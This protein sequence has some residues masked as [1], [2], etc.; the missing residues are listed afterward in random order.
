MR[1]AVSIMQND[2]FEDKHMLLRSV[3]RL[4]VALKHYVW[5]LLQFFR[6]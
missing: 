5:V 3:E 4:V 6:A 2:E 1:I